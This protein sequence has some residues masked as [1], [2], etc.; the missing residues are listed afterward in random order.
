MYEYH[1]IVTEVL[2]GDTLNLM[3]DLGFDPIYRRLKRAR[4][5]GIDAPEKNTQLGLDAKTYLVARLPAGCKVRINTI[6]TKTSD[7]E[8]TE[9]F[10][11][12]LVVV[13]SLDAD[14]SINDELINQGHAKTYFGGARG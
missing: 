9:K 8:K 12:F 14:M 4:L 1:A 5:Y 10:G 3:V 6:K 7:F 2:D 11:G 13:Y